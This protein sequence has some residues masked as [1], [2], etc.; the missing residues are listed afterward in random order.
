MV[1]VPLRAL[2]ACAYLRTGLS[3]L[4]R[5][6]YQRGRRPQEH[7]SCRIVEVHGRAA[8]ADHGLDRA[9][10]QL[11]G[12]DCGEDRDRSAPRHPPDQGAHEVV[13]GSEAVTGFDFLVAQRL[14]S[15]SNMRRLR[16]GSI[17]SMRGLVAVAQVGRHPAR[18]LRDALGVGHWRS[19][20]LIGF[21]S[22]RAVLRWARHARAG[23][24]GNVRWASS[25]FVAYRRLGH[26]RG[27]R[28]LD[29]R[30]GATTGRRITNAGCVKDQRPEN[31]R[32]HSS[33]APFICHDK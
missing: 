26:V 23:G 18:R 31:P 6:P 4:N 25:H 10:D 24:N 7:G 11:L 29:V 22:E 5:L 1:S 16:A 32:Q 8:E 2:S 33:I 13:V 3:E 17:G 12:R 15:R 21:V 14:M 30:C 20:R 27:L 9:F 19:G 28:I